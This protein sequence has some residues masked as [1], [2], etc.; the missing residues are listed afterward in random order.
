MIK[1]FVF[2]FTTLGTYKIVEQKQLVHYIHCIIS[3][4]L[5]GGKTFHTCHCS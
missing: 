4:D 1:T 2:Y 5:V 3:N